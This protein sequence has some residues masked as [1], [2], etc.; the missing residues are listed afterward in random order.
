MSPEEKIAQ[1]ERLIA[2]NE[3]V[4]RGEG[5]NVWDYAGGNVDDA[6]Q[7]GFG[8]GENSMAEAIRRILNDRQ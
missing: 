7:M 6:Y 5:F 4:E 1:I 3:Y 8:D 2:H